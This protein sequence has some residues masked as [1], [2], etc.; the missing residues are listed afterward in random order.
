V[1]SEPM[2]LSSRHRTAEICFEELGVPA[3]CVAKGPE[4]AAISVGRVTALV[5]DIGGHETTCTPIVDGAAVFRSHGSSRLAGSSISLILEK[6]LNQLGETLVPLCAMRHNR[7]QPTSPLYQ[8]RREDLARDI[9]E[10]VCRVHET[11]TSP[12]NQPPA[13]YTL[14]DGRI[15]SVGT[16]RFDVGEWYFSSTSLHSNHVALQ[17]LVLSTLSGMDPDYHK[18]LIRNVV[19]T[20]GGSCL[21]GLPERFEN[22]LRVMARNSDALSISNQAHRLAVLSGTVSERKYGTWTGGS[23]L[24]SMGSHTQLWMSRAEYDEHGAALI[25]KKGLNYVW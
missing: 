15:L 5:V 12:K 20:G 9:C 14:P 7:M 8:L 22:E 24:G 6:Q 25:S 10:S 17:S 21:S 18:E 19:L 2:S 16:E 3:L 1:L 13:E 11:P 4:L 23:I